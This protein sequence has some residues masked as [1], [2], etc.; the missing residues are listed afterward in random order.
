MKQPNTEPAM[1]S[2]RES[3]PYEVPQ[4]V[5]IPITEAEVICTVFL[6]KIFMWL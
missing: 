4:I 6:L 5:S 3:F 1:F 2:L